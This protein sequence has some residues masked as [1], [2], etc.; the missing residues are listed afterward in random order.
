[1]GAT[2]WCMTRTHRSITRRAAVLLTI[3]GLTACSS[4]HVIDRVAWGKELTAQ[5]LTVSDWDKYE[6]SALSMCA[7]DDP[8]MFLAVFTDG[9]ASLKSI[10]TNYRNACPERLD[11]FQA[12]VRS[13]AEAKGSADLAC[14]TPADKRTQD[15]AD[16]AEAMG[17]K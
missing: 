9:G 12:G 5:G 8:S 10:E 17:C 15:Q 6:K 13:L 11:R 3:V 2:L 14:G 7:Q 4:T 1:M 16:F